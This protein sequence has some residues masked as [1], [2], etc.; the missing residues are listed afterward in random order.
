MLFQDNIIMIGASTGGPKVL[1]DIF[2]KL[3]P[4]H[5]AVI[6]VQ[7]ILPK[8]DTN[9]T[10][11]LNSASSMNVVLAGDG[12]F[13]ETGSV[14]VAPAGVHLSLE[15]NTRIKLLPGQK[16]NYCCPSIDVAMNSLEETGTGKIVGVVLTGMGRDGA[17]GITHIK[18]IKG[19]TIAQDKKSS[20]IYGMPMEAQNTGNVDFVLSAA[21]IG[22]KLVELVGDARL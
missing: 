9:F 12:D 2:S 14:F 16:V 5:A 1:F 17:S 13:L 7:H 20:V 22:H 15:Q 6:I 18:K 10:A 4:V 21:D 19:V 3:P 11:C 8:Y